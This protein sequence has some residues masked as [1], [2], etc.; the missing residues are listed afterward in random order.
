MQ[1]LHLKKSMKLSKDNCKVMPDLV[2]MPCSESCGA[3]SAQLCRGAFAQR[4]YFSR[5]L[6]L[7]KDI[8]LSTNAYPWF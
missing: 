7:A 1:C 8:V 3:Q 2:E 4:K 6:N 5:T